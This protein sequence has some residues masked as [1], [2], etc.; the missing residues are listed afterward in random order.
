MQDG[1]QSDAAVLAIWNRF[2]LVLIVWSGR[3][4]VED[5][6]RRVRALDEAPP[7]RLEPGAA[8][9]SGSPGEGT[10]PCPSCSNPW[11]RETFRRASKRVAGRLAQDPKRAP[12][13]P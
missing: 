5:V 1:C 4:R 12:P 11:V 8:T 6:D 9:R 13:T 3:N 7:R 2:V 10:E